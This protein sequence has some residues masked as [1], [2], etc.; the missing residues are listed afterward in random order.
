MEQH[1]TMRLICLIFA[2]C[3]LSGCHPKAAAPEPQ[4][5]P[6]IENHRYPKQHPVRSRDMLVKNCTVTGESGNRAD[7]ICRHATTH[8]DANDPSK[9]MMVCK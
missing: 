8:L 6:T 9:Q 3:I 2:I 1:G 7:C 4:P 5:A